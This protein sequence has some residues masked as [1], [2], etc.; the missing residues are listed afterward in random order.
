[1]PNELDN[2]IT[3]LESRVDHMHCAMDELKEEH[4]RKMDRV[5]DSLDCIKDELGKNKGFFAGIVFTVSACFALVSY[6]FTG[7]YL[8]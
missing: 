5:Q 3:S 6:L 4:R 2:R 8:K 7:H 1:M